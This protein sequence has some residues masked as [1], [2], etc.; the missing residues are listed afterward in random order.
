MCDVKTPTHE[1]IEAL[2]PERLSTVGEARGWNVGYAA[3]WVDGH[4]AGVE[5]GA[6]RFA[7][8]LQ[9]HTVTN[10]TVSWIEYVLVHFLGRR[11]RRLPPRPGTGL[12][13]GE[14]QK[15]EGA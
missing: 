10:E 14:G 11:D 2:R 4:A 7:E 15:E 6:R 13:T 12:A 3:G 8:K 5:E 9:E 1:E